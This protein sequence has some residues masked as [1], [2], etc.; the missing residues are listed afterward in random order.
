MVS[1]HSYTKLAYMYSEQERQ[2]VAQRVKIMHLFWKGSWE[3][4]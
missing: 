1:N 4:S 2:L 3:E